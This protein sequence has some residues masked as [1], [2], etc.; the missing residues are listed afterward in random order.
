V[1]IL[2]K[3]YAASGRLEGFKKTILGIKRGG[4]WLRCLENWLYKKLWTCRKR[5][6][7]LLTKASK[8]P[9]SCDFNVIK[10]LEKNFGWVRNRKKF[11]KWET[12]ILWREWDSYMCHNLYTKG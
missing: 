1:K 7:R 6:Y 4:T 5:D 11:E 10:R 12:L 2:E 8:S 3:A 9:K